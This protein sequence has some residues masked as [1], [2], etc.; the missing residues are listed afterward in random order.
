[1]L[2]P[3]K[4]IILTWL[5]FIAST[6]VVVG[7]RGVNWYFGKKS[8]L[9]FTTAG[10]VFIS[11]SEMSTK[12][13][14]S[15]LS[16]ENGN[17]LFYT[18]GVTVWNKNNAIMVNGTGL[19]G[20]FSSAQSSIVVPDPSNPFRYYL[21]TSV[22]IEAPISSKVYCYNIIDMSQ[23]GG[24]GEVV[25][26][27]IVFDTL[28]SERL[29]VA[30]HNNGTDFWILTNPQNSNIFK[31]FLLSSTGLSSLPRVS[32]V[33]NIITAGLGMMKVSN[34]GRWLVQTAY[35]F[36][37]TSISPCQLFQF[38]N[39]N[40]AVSN[41]LTLT[42]PQNFSCS[43]GC[44]FSPDNSR[45]YIG[46]LDATKD[47]VQF[48]LV[49]GID[50]LINK[51][52]V[53]IP[54]NANVN[55]SGLGDFSVAPDGKM[56]IARLDS[57]RLSA[58]TNPNDTG[59]VINFID[60]AFS[61]PLGSESQLGLPNFYNSINLPPSKIKVDRLSCLQYKFTFTDTSAYNFQGV[62]RWNF[63]DGSSPSNFVS[64]THTFTRSLTDSF[65]VTLNF[66]S[67]NNLIS[68]NQEVWVKL[69]PKPVAKFVLPTT[70]C[71][72]D[73][74]RFLNNSTSSNGK[75]INHFWRFSDASTSTVVNP[76]KRFTD[77]GTYPIK[78]VV[79]DTIGC[80]S[81]TSIQS[82]SLNKI[83][84]AN[85][86][87]IGPF[88]AT[89]PLLINDLTTSTNVTLN[90][91]WFGWNSNNS[92][93][94]TINGNFSPT[95]PTEG[96]YTIQAF[97]NSIEGCKSDTVTKSYFIYNRPTANF[98]LPKNCVLDVSNFI[99]TSTLLGSSTINLN[100]WDFG[101]NG[102]L[103]DT[104]I[105]QNPSYQYN[106]TNTYPVKLSVRTNRG[107][108]DSLTQNFT[109][110]GAIPNAKLAFAEN[111]ICSGDSI[112]LLNQSSVN[113]GN[114]TKMEIIWG[115]NFLVDNNP[116][117][118]NK[119]KFKFI[120]FGTPANT[121]QPIKI[122]A[123]SGISCFSEK[124]TIITLRAQPRVSFALPVD[125]ICGN[126]LPI[127]LSQ[128]IE[129]NG[130]IGSFNYNGNGVRQIGVN[131]FQFIPRLVTQNSVA[132]L[133]YQFTTPEGCT[134]SITRF[135]KVLPFPL[136]NA[137]P[138]RI[139]LNGEQTILLASAFGNNLQYSWTPP[140]ITNNPS[141]LQPTVLTNRDTTLLFT[142][143][144][145]EGCKDTSS[146]KVS[147]YPPLTPPNAFSPNSDAINDN[148]IIPNIGFYANCE[149][150]IFNRQGQ[151]VFKSL[152]Y[153]V[154]WDG[155]FQG[156]PL[157]VATYYYLIETGTG[158]KP[159]S[160]WVLLLR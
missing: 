46:C 83:V 9:K 126:E 69:P 73:T 21:F 20:N 12:E 34:D 94:S 55:S 156:K 110:N 152:G 39:T 97:V 2:I 86:E 51:S 26:K 6:L 42:L 109:V 98:I 62:Y 54:L 91:W 103:N 122:K 93:S 24:L 61:L 79:I 16:D 105:L 75:I 160:G 140:A 107:C 78:L 41:P 11:G 30:I 121:I 60:S 106:A 57:R 23:Q 63:G 95:F 74:L 142:A 87:L 53:V 71:V 29:T 90:N 150:F 45:F 85:F 66:R 22:Q 143:T 17:L 65:L 81:D 157:P 111:P 151:Q 129:T 50:S 92:Y 96:F 148:W 27:N 64:P 76:I 18:D 52:G 128:G 3:N 10:P 120:E 40:G 13:G 116:T 145:L 43:Y 36:S 147:I 37:N 115:I 108:T 47:F 137:G 80:V 113:F 88:C 99:N 1:M 132:S 136:V 138:D 84:R 7:Q 155:T 33:G 118:N 8:A 32:N 19:R 146:V 153:K 15:T 56:Y 112:V 59:T 38:N 133:R 144:N 130:A 159:I 117:S 135:I 131:E 89:T 58:I 31:A 28:C 67:P 102:I 134:D 14:C 139:K 49:S 44:A 5:F 114:I 119:Y 4:N 123:F 25:V 35:S 68:I 141:I 82:V 149:V 48:T 125:S 101:V 154:P 127:T 100:K 158:R 70:T 104:S 77:T 72:N 124:D